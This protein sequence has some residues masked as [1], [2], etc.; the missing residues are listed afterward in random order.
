MLLTAG[1][2]S[3]ACGS[4]KEAVAPQ[5]NIEDDD[6]DDPDDGLEMMQQCGGMNENKIN[7]AVRRV[8]GELGECLMAGYEDVEL[9]GGD[10]QF[11]IEINSK[12][13]AQAVYVEKSDLGSHLVEQCMVDALK[14]KKW[15]KPVG[16]TLGVAHTAMGFS[17]PEDLR[18]PIA[19]TAADV[20]SHLKKQEAQFAECGTEGGPFE[21]TAYIDASGKVMS[22]GVAHVDAGGNDVS[23]CLLAK[24]EESRF[25]SPGSYPA[26][27]QFALGTTPLSPL[28]CE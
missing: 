14:A 11:L 28:T 27:V 13:R 3:G 26:K 22:A 23:E 18:A 25:P 15:P 1:L 2:F 10:V 16:S 17:P 9:L 24:I 21:F 12:G 6:G 19:W 8:Q 7:R 4:P 20:R 5:S